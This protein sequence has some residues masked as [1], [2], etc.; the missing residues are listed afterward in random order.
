MAFAKIRPVPLANISNAVIYARYSSEKQTENSIDGQLRECKKYCDFHGYNI[1]NEY[2]DRAASGTTDNR[3][4]FQRM[5]E[6]SAKQQFAYVI[7]YRFDR[8]ARNR[9]DSAIYKKKL[10]QNGVRV[11]SVSENIGDGDEG[12]ILESI[13]EAMDEAYS[14]RLSR[15]T[16]RGMRETALKGLWTGG[17][18]PLG[19]KVENR[20]LVI[21]SREAAAVRLIF[22]RYVQGKTKKQ[23]A[24]ELNAAGYRTKN[25]KPFTHSNFTTVMRNKM[26]YG[27]YNFEDV[28][29][30]CPAIVSKELFDQVQ[31]LQEINKKCFGANCNSKLQ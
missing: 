24:D 28:E 6:D 13:Y 17:I 19:Y 9:F 2:I 8:F 30:A 26:Y 18:V 27:N 12:I 21:E 10:E 5:I 31:Q 16:K 25:G 3:P 14:R 29:R 7:V 15:I 11:L 22:E 23:I 4:E 1:I 20:R